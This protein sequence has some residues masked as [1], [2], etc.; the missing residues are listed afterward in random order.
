MQYMSNKHFF[1]LK[2]ICIDPPNGYP[3]VFHLPIHMHFQQKNIG[4]VKSN[5]SSV[6]DD[7]K[8]M[9]RQNLEEIEQKSRTGGKYLSFN[10]IAAGNTISMA[11]ATRDA[12]LYSVIGIRETTGV[13]ENL[14][15]A[16]FQLIVWIFPAHD[17][18]A[19]ASLLVDEYFI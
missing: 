11:F 12:N 3:K 10:K 19:M 15:L 17:D 9:I 6:M 7:L 13:A 18:E 16:K 4:W 2:I 1:H 8:Y 14:P 5:L